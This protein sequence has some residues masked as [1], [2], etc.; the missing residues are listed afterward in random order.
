MRV[1][2]R[3]STSVFG[4]WNPVLRVPVLGVDERDATDVSLANVDTAAEATEGGG[5]DGLSGS[6]PG[7]ESL[8]GAGRTTG[9]EGSGGRISTSGGG[10]NDG[11]GAENGGGIAGWYGVCGR[12]NITDFSSL[13]SSSES[14][15]SSSVPSSTATSTPRRAN[16]LHAVHTAFQNCR[17]IRTKKILLRTAPEDRFGLMAFS[18]DER[19]GRL[20]DGF[21]CE[22]AAEEED[23][24]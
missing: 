15:S 20:E 9:V 19:D 24:C 12:S 1:S 22:E 6:V 11:S 14:F 10:G 21:D 5:R 8:A 23:C 3:S 16:V 18:V 7:G 4:R 17:M 2:S 13:L